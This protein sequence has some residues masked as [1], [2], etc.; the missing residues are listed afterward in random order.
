MS[1]NDAITD[2]TVWVLAGFVVVA[3]GNLVGGFV[4][5]LA[6]IGKPLFAA[7]WLVTHFYGIRLALT[8]VSILVGNVVATELEG[9]SA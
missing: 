9:H 1:V 5:Q 3:V 7:I 2:A 8:G 6:L 4:A